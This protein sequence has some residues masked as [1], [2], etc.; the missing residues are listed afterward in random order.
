LEEAT[1]YNKK[2]GRRI[3]KGKEEEEKK[4]KKKIQTVTGRQHTP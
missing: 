3:K 1:G 2:N 4:K